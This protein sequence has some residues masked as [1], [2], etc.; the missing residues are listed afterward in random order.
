MLYL[1][2]RI[3]IFVL[4]FMFVFLVAQVGAYAYSSENVIDNLGYLTETEVQYLQSS[5]DR[6][7][8]NYRLDTVIVITDD[9]AGKSSRDFADDFF[10]NNGYGIGS[11]YSGLLLLINMNKR[12]VY[13][14]TSGKAFDIF[15]DARIDNILDDVARFLSNGNYYAACSEFISNVKSYAYSGVPSNQYRVDTDRNYFHN[16]LSMM[17]FFPIYIVAL[18]ISV[19]ATL[20]VTYSSKGKTTTNHLTYEV[21]G[22]FDL[23]ENQNNYIRESTVRTRIESS[24]SGGGSGRSSTHRSSSGR[25]HGGGGRKF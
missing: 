25:T 20:V 19:I 6:I 23:T 1:F 3:S 2:K 7:K 24:S 4:I 21:N 18:I 17:K 13:I 11:D 5:I 22:S 15:T 16:V 14:S 10:D 12:D 8:E 9:T